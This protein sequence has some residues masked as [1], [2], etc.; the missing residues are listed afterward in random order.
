MLSISSICPSIGIA[1]ANRLTRAQ[2]PR[3][4]TS[5]MSVS[6]LLGSVLRCDLVAQG[7]TF[8]IALTCIAQCGCHHATQYEGSVDPIIVMES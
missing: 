5:Q 7:G 2:S 4:M 8:C 1:N 3:T 6:S